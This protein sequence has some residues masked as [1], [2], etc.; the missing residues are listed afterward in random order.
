MC[1]TDNHANEQFFEMMIFLELKNVCQLSG[2]TNRLNEYDDV[3][4]KPLLILVFI[5]YV[6]IYTHE[7]SPHEMDLFGKRRYYHMFQNNPSD[8]HFL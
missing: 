8:I 1:T 4:M 6:R 2:L 5:L 7:E 3:I